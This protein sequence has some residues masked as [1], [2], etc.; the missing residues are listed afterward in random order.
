[1]VGSIGLAPMEGAN[2][3]WGERLTAESDASPWLTELAAGVV[4]AIGAVVGGAEE[5][6]VA[7]F[8]RFGG[9]DAGGEAV[10]AETLGGERG[11]GEADGARAAEVLDGAAVELLG[12]EIFELVLLSFGFPASGTFGF[13][14]VVFGAG[15]DLGGEE[16]GEER[17]RGFF[18]GLFKDVFTEEGVEEGLESLV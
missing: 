17:S 5:G 3:L 4:R 12:E 2:N 15:C 18:L 6:K 1:M 13:G 10:F 8:P 9:E 7:V 11:G 16:L 14:S